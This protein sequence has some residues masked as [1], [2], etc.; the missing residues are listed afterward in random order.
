MKIDNIN[1]FT[2]GWFIGNFHPSLYKTDN[3]EVALQS[4]VKGY[5][6]PR[7][8]HEKTTEFNLIVSGKVKV[9]NEILSYGD[10]F[11]YEPYEVS[12]VEFLEDTSLVVIRN[13]SI[14]EDKVLL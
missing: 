13:G 10:L 7:H 4:H 9:K 2:K 8:Y 11:I 14:P 12:E 3:F 1:N 6:A 5:T